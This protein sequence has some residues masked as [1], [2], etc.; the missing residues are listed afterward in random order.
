M[1]R[2]SQKLSHVLLLSAHFD[3]WAGYADSSASQKSRVDL[4]ATPY[5]VLLTGF[6]PFL[7]NVENPTSAIVSHLNASGCDDMDVLPATLAP[8]GGEVGVRLRI[9]WHTQVLPVNRSGALW[10]TEHLQSLGKIPYD[11]IFHTGLENY[12]KGMKLE[13]AASNTRANDTGAGGT[14]P[15]VAGAQDVLPTTV[16]IGWMTLKT[17]EVVNKSFRRS[18]HEIELWSRDPGRFYCNEVYY[19]TLHFVRSKPVRVGTGALLPVMFVHVQNTTSSSIQE[20]VDSIRQVAAHALWSTYLAPST[21]ENTFGVAHATA[22]S[23]GLKVL[24]KFS[25]TIVAWSGL[26]LVCMLTGALLLPWR[27][28]NRSAQFLPEALRAP[29]TATA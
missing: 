25:T 11:A 19:R 9:C 6:G 3:A 14:L 20:D 27:C 2:F 13:I 4:T 22:E 29:L 18:S 5:N 10:T 8:V 7:G 17:L 24:L 28:A 15:A 26:M 1:A 16:N 12:A 21:E 23:S